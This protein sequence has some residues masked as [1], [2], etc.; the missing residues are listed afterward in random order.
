MTRTYSEQRQL[1]YFKAARDLRKVAASVLDDVVN[2]GELAQQHTIVWA[3]NNASIVAKQA[4]ALESLGHEQC[5]ASVR[6]ETDLY[7]SRR[8][9]DASIDAF[10]A[11]VKARGEV[12]LDQAHKLANPLRHE[13]V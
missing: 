6:A 8:A 4:Y 7:K 12:D 9:Y 10:E 5:V 1:I 2:D 3:I 11:R 13:R